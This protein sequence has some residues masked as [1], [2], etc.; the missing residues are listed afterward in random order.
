MLRPISTKRL[1]TKLE[2]YDYNVL[3]ELEETLIEAF[4]KLSTEELCAYMPS[5]IETGGKALWI[6][7]AGNII[8]LDLHQDFGSET[9]YVFCKDYLDVNPELAED[10]SVDDLALQDAN[11]FNDHLVDDLCWLKYNGGTIYDDRCYVC[12]PTYINEKQYRILRDIIKGEESDG[13]LVLPQDT[14]QDKYYD[15]SLNDADDIIKKIRSYYVSHILDESLDRYNGM[16]FT[17][18]P[19]TIRDLCLNKPDAYRILY[20]ANIDLYMLCDASLHI[21]YDLITQAYNLGYYHDIDKVPDLDPMV[22]EYVKDRDLFNYTDIGV[23]GFYDGDNCIVEVGQYLLYGI[24]VPNGISED[25]IDNSPSSDGYD[26]EIKCPAGS[27]FTRG[28]D[29]DILTKCKLISLLKKS[30]INVSESIS[31]AFIN[32]IT[33]AWDRDTCH[34]AFVNKYSN[35]NPAAGQCLVTALAVQDEY[36]GDIYDCKV[37]RSRHFYNVIDGE[38]VDLTFNQFPEGSEIKEPRIRD[39]KQLLNNKDTKARYDLLKLRMSKTEEVLQSMKN[40]KLRINEN[41]DDTDTEFIDYVLSLF[42]AWLYT[43]PK[44]ALG[45]D[46]YDSACGR[47]LKKGLTL[48]K[49]QRVIDDMG[50]Y[51]DYVGVEIFNKDIDLNH[52]SVWDYLDSYEKYLVVE[53]NIAE[54]LDTVGYDEGKAIFDNWKAGNKKQKELPTVKSKSVDTLNYTDLDELES[55]EVEEI[56][57]DAGR[58]IYKADASTFPFQPVFLLIRKTGYTSTFPAVSDKGGRD[59]IVNY[60]NGVL[61]SMKESVVKENLSLDNVFKY[62]EKPDERREYCHYLINHELNLRNKTGEFTTTD[63]NTYEMALAI[64][65][66]RGDLFVRGRKINNNSFV[67]NYE[68]KPIKKDTSVTEVVEPSSTDLGKAINSHYS[69]L[70]TKY[71]PFKVSGIYLYDRLAEASH[72]LISLYNQQYWTY[73]KDIPGYFNTNELVKING[74]RKPKTFKDVANGTPIQKFDSIDAVLSYLMFIEGDAIAEVQD[75]LGESIDENNSNSSYTLW[76]RS[77]FDKDITHRALFPDYTYQTYEEANENIREFRRSC[78]S[79]MVTGIAEVVNGKVVKA[80]RLFRGQ[81]EREDLSIQTENLINRENP[82]Y[83]NFNEFWFFV[84]KYWLDCNAEYSAL[85]DAFDYG[86]SH[87]EARFTDCP[88]FYDQWN[89]EGE[90][91][92]LAFEAGQES[93]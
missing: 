1:N 10:Y 45:R 71:A 60:V 62:S 75:I 61:N 41:W 30:Q 74:E 82:P 90:Y 86:M 51:L 32:K 53:Q 8:R 7:P 93:A 3:C 80:W 79:H 14:R 17:D 70:N 24:W 57:T 63:R 88:V 52:G 26:T 16:I 58:I 27:L 83:Y 37:G 48:P 44:D 28:A 65:K 84:A 18:S 91:L 59:K 76:T 11:A 72:Y 77:M 69:D 50:D 23:I 92:E 22:V 40:V 66:V 33:S 12:L 6:T 39:R 68:R 25:E 36:G 46:S 78:A 85:N 31:N 67:I 42:E 2:S 38:T 54:I 19:Y 81:L 20:D 49:A 43:Q 34:P 15:F 29:T 13:L 64:L 89:H 73:P 56:V 55:G 5:S 87:P 35:E 47:F 9:F 21:H 4:Y